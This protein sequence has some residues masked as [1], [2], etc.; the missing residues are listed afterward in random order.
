M[1]EKLENGTISWPPGISEQVQST[2]KS[3]VNYKYWQW[4]GFLCRY[5]EADITSN[6]E[7]TEDE[8]EGLLLACPRVWRVRFSLA[9]VH[10]CAAVR[11]NGYCY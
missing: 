2:A 1:Y 8:K 5:T 10:P 9:Q 11:H 6:D 3:A 7:A 4:H